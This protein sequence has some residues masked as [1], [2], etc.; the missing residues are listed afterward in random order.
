MALDPSV[1]PGDPVCVEQDCPQFGKPAA[2]GVCAQCGQ[3]TEVISGRAGAP[4]PAVIGTNAVP[5]AP[6]EI[7]HRLVARL[8]D[9]AVVVA[10]LCVVALLSSVVRYV[11]E[12]SGSPIFGVLFVAWYAFVLLY[13]FVMLAARNGQTF[14]KRLMKLRV[15]KLDGRPVGWGSAA[16]RV[17]VPMLASLCTGGLAGLLFALS[18]LFDS[19]PW[20]RGW[21]DH[22]AS[23]VVVRAGN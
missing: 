20:R 11:G 8:I 18:P 5:G 10:P 4:P 14:G 17:Y 15:V 3:P 23:T 13:E 22:I 9:V 16:G 7:S 19:S 2:G 12:E 1:R 21:P 6:A